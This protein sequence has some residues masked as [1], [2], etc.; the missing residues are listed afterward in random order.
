MYFADHRI[1]R[2]SRPKLGGDLG[3]AQPVAPQ[4]A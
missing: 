3:G 1:S 4:L 2:N